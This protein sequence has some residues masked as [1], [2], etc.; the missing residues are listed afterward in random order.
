MTTIYTTQKLIDPI[1]NKW[2]GLEDFFLSN[3]RKLLKGYRKVNKS[4]SFTDYVM[5]QYLLMK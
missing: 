3:E 1:S 4:V 2:E 5:N